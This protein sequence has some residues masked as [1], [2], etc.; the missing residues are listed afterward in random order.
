[1]LS[2]WA[3]G[4]VASKRAGGRRD[5]HHCHARSRAGNPTRPSARAPAGIHRPRGR[6]SR[7]PAERPR[8]KRAP[9][10]RAVRYPSRPTE[11]AVGRLRALWESAHGSSFPPRRRVSGDVF[12]AADVAIRPSTRSAMATTAARRRVGRAPAD[13]GR[14][15]PSLSLRRSVPFRSTIGHDRSAGPL[16]RRRPLKRIP[17]LKEHHL[18]DAQTDVCPQCGFALGP[19]YAYGLGVSDTGNGTA[20]SNHEERD[21]PNCGSTLRRATGGVWHLATEADPGQE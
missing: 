8:P 13:G 14:R 17:A 11:G 21:C 3:S 16:P 18:G 15:R 2:S 9:W 7:F 20:R 1:M 19:S 5:L 12:G 10:S 6:R 4:P